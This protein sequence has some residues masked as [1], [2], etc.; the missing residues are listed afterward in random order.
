MPVRITRQPRGDKKELLSQRV[1]TQPRARVLIYIYAHTHDDECRIDARR[2]K[3][4]NGTRRMGIYAWD[5]FAEN[6][7]HE[8]VGG[9]SLA[10]APGACRYAP[11]PFCP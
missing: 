1:E 8:P 10:A 2:S 5:F 9:G 7:A 3:K 11:R 4:L 6:A